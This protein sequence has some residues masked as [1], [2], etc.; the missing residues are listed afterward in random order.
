MI[1]DLLIVLVL[2]VLNRLM[3]SDFFSALKNQQNEQAKASKALLRTMRLRLVNAWV[4]VFKD[5]IERYRRLRKLQSD[6]ESSTWTTRRVRVP[7]EA[8]F[9]ASEGEEEGP[10]TSAKGKTAT[11]CVLLLCVTLSHSQDRHSTTTLSQELRPR[12]PL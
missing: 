8:I 2:A 12:P 11:A 6:V 1:F 4:T 3:A 7:D 9:T 10:V 5:Q